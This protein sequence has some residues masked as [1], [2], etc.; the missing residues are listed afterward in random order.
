[1]VRAKT[2]V[3]VLGQGN[4]VQA[5]GNALLFARLRSLLLPWIR[6]ECRNG[7]GTVGFAADLQVVSLKV[8]EFFSPYQADRA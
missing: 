7:A 5:F 8:D 3:G 4:P 6:G 2:W 1:V